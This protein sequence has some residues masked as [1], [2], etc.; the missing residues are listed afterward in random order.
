MLIKSLENRIW[1]WTQSRE[2][3]LFPFPHST[4]AS[5]PRAAV[6]TQLSSSV[7]V[8]IDHPGLPVPSPELTLP[9]LA[10]HNQDSG[11]RERLLSRMGTLDILCS[12]GKCLSNCLQPGDGGGG[13]EYAHLGGE[14]GVLVAPWF[15]AEEPIWITRGAR[16][17]S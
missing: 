16:E 9:F 15:I 12:G 13:R 10:S 7:C 5:R 14:P 8:S 4:F 6:T 3:P 2:V 1:I 17:H 11:V